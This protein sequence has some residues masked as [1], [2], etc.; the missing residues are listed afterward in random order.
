MGQPDK[1]G[2]RKRRIARNLALG[3]AVSGLAMWWILHDIERERIFAILSEV[4]PSYLLLATA[5]TLLS[6]VIRAWRWP[7]FFE[8]SAPG[9]GDSFRCLMVGFFMNN[10]LPARLGEFVRAHLGGR[11]TNLSR[12]LVLAT[13]AGE[14]LADGLMISTMFAVLFGLTS[15]RAEFNDSQEL[16]YV[17][18][19]FAGIAL[20]TGIVLWQ[21]HRAYH[22]LERLGHIFPGH[23]SNYT[24][25]RIGKFIEGLEPMLHLPRLVRISLMTIVAWSV[26]LLVYSFVAKAFGQSLSVGNLA[27]FLAAVN[28]SSL[29]PAAPGGVGVIEAFATLALVHVGVERETALAMVV[30]Q[31]IIQMLVVGIPGSLYFV[32]SMG[33]KLPESDEEENG[34]IASAEFADVSG[35]ATNNDQDADSFPIWPD[36]GTKVYLSV[37]VPA[38]NEEDRLPKTLLSITEFLEASD[39]TYEV[40]VVNDGSSDGTDKVVHQFE[41][42]SPE[43]KLLQYGENRGKGYAVRFGVMHA[44][45]ELIL[46]TDA[47]GAS[48]IEEL[49]RL[50]N[51]I[52][53]GAQV[54][55]GS[56]ALYS[57]DTQVSTLWVRKFMGRVF[58]GIVNFV[59]LPGIADTQCGFK[60]FRRP[61]ARYVFS[62]SKSE[63]FSFDVEILYLARKAGAKIAEVPINWTNVPGS[64]VNLVS[65]SAKMFR[66]ILIFRMR[67]VFGGY[68]KTVGVDEL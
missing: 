44:A 58:N 60:L 16:L 61:V 3:F 12:S 32:F 67:D 36:E 10:V 14:R 55:I 42:L 23:L 48:P 41:R 40:L 35:S 38:Y 24:L 19:G 39:R 46:Y 4:D 15:T 37:I 51:A 63:G 57:Q 9:F 28:F 25:V 33:G 11:A 47:D 30:S 29:I 45:G 34:Q 64:K 66:D 27:L 18:Y 13:I 53:K 17:A 5:A 22:Y 20:M 26:E 56:R 54:A 6:Y 65:D 59:M 8:S 50:E 1:S 7:V 52:T 68:G 21:R 49:S 31:H 2:K 62:R 43:V